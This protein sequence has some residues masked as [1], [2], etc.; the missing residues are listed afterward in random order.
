MAFER[1]DYGM[2]SGIPFIR[3]ADGVEV[4]VAPEGERIG[5]P[6]DGLEEVLTVALC[7]L[8]SAGASMGADR[9]TDGASL[10]LAVSR[11]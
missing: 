3:I 2:I 9:T 10:R 4:D 7:S 8:R 6:S 1:K 11:W 5:D